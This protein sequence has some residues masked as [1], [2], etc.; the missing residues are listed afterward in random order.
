MRTIVLTAACLIFASLAFGQ[1]DPYTLTVIATRP[2]GAQP[3]QAVI[4]VYVE[5]PTSANLN[6]VLAVVQG[7]GL[8]QSNLA[9]VY[10]VID[11]PG[12]QL[13]QAWS[14]QLT[15]LYAA[16]KDTLTKLGTLQATIAKQNPGFSVTYQV[17]GVQVS[18]A[19]QAAQPCP[20]AA[21][22]ADARA[23]AQVLAQAAGF[24]V[25]QISTI[26]D[27]SGVAS[28]V[29]GGLVSIQGSLG[30]LFVPTPSV[31]TCAIA[32]KFKLTLN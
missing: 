13:N 23:Q 10:G 24:G 2:L 11:G 22:V 20:L 1:L 12:A 32:V 5:T 18:A 28:Q 30:A 14:F 3:D 27:G 17:S 25:G 29:S 21:M 9:S 8:T 16:I 19:A 7:F 31:T 4:N 26:T 6:D 15:I